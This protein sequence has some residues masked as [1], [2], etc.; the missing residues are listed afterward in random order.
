MEMGASGQ[1]GRP[2]GCDGFPFLYDLP[3]G[4]VESAGVT[5]KRGDTIAMVNDDGVAVAAVPACEN[6]DARVGSSDSRTVTGAKVEASVKASAPQDRMG[7]PTKA[8]GNGAVG[9]VE[10]AA[11]S[12]DD[13]FVAAASG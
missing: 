10:H 2:H 12:P 7:A 4:D 11:C 5:V 6:D 1:P 3:F 8:A 9:G 13:D